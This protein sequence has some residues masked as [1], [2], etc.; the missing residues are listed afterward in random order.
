MIAECPTDSAPYA[1]AESTHYL[2]QICSAEFDPWM[3][4]YYMSQAKD[5]SS[6]LELT[7]PNPD[8]AR[9]LVFPNDDYTYV[10]ARDRAQPEQTNAYLEVHNPDGSV[11]SEALIYFY[12]QGE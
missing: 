10:L 5:G 3:P 11:Q 7:N 12:E 2:I 9:Q 4:K 1:F 8:T 6:T